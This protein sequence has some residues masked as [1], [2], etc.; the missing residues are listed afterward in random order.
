[1][2]LVQSLGCWNAW[3]T[4]LARPRYTTQQWCWHMNLYMVCLK[5]Y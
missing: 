2:I 1:M 3:F 4:T 5:V